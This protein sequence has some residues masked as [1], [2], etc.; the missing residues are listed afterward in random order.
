MQ[1]RAL[2]ARIN[3]IA[4]RQGGA[5]TWAQ[6]RE[7]GMGKATIGRRVSTGVWNRPYPGVYV[8]GG[9]P[10]TRPQALWAA[11]LAAGGGAAVSHESGAL[12]HGARGLPLEPLT[13]TAPHGAHHRLPGVT[14][15]QI[16]D[17]APRHRTT[18]DGLPVVTAA[19]AVVELGSRLSLDRL[20]DVADDLVQSRATTW[21]AIGAVFRDVARP[22]KPG[23]PT[24]ASLLDDRCGTG[25][26]A[27]SALE[28]ALFTALAA[29]GLPAPVR[30][31]ALPGRGALRGLVDA[32][33]LDARILLE[34]DGR[35]YHMRLRD[36]RR[37]R[38]RDAQA[39]A[40]GWVT[41][42]FMYDQVVGDP[43]GACADIAAAR[44][45]R[46][47]LFASAA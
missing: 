1:T 15:H 42:R 4:R 28:R 8:L 2:D 36:M 27:A 19:R 35:T 39:V 43:A 23:M 29:A 47:P 20:G 26:P 25:V 33:Y 13:L 10:P 16:D 5:F 18:I 34:T 37:D 38:E 40:A 22:G 17:L 11:V 14:V 31:M 44:R 24:V 12:V 45:V 9:T 41:L 32:A 21:P 6:A 30:Q 46:L 7:C 3:L